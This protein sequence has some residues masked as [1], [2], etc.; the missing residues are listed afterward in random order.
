MPFISCQAL[1]GHHSG[2]RSTFDKCGSSERAEFRARPFENTSIQYTYYG[3]IDRGIQE[4]GANG[5]T[6]LE[7]QGGH[8]Q[9]LEVQSLLPGGWR[10]VADLNELSSLTFRLAFADSFGEAITSEV[11][12]ATFLTNNFRGFS[13]NFAGLSDKTFLSIPIT[14]STT[15]VT[16]PAVSVTLRDAPE[17][18]FGSVEQAPWQNLPIYFSFD[19]F[20]DALHR[21]DDTP[22]NTPGFV[23]RTNL[24]DR[25]APRQAQGRGS[26]PDPRSSRALD[27]RSRS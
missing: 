8:Q 24:P 9:Q 21:Q 12:S 27:R 20:A 26:A 13:L 22:V 14:S 4:P 5:T 18:R 15:G 2:R 10:F 6:Y 11:P 7:K 19:A 25:S 3:V 1:A 16:T 17:V 23:P